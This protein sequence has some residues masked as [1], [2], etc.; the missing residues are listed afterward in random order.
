M[1]GLTKFLF[2]LRSLFSRRKLDAQ[3]TEEIKLHLEMEMEAK[4][5]A[6]MTPEEARYSALREFGNI[7]NIQEKTRDERGWVWL[8]KIWLD[9]R[10]AARVLRKSP[11]FSVT[12][13]LTVSIG[14]GA[15][16]ALFTI[17]NGVLLRPLPF[18]QPDRVVMI[19][20]T[21]SGNVE[22]QVSPAVY[23]DW[24]KQTS[25][26]E[27]L[28]ILSGRSY[29]SRLPGPGEK[30]RAQCVTANYFSVLGV[31]A[32][33]GRT[34]RS[35]EEVEGRNRVVVLSYSFWQSHFGGRDDVLNETL[36]LDDEAYTIVG[37]MPDK[38]LV[39]NPRIFTPRIS[40]TEDREDYGS[41][42]FVCIGRLKPGVSL[43]VAQHELDVVSSRIAQT[44]PETNR[45]RGA[46]LVPLL[47]SLV[48]NVRVQLLT[49]L[50]AVGFLLLIAGTN[51]AGLMLTRA[52]SRAHEIAVR[53]ALGAGQ[54]R[55][56]RQILCESLLIAVMGGVLGTMMAYG[57][58]GPLVRFAGHHVPRTDQIQLDGSVLAASIGL[59]LLTGLCAGLLAAVQS[60]RE[61]MIEPLR[62]VTIGRFSGRRRQRART[63][64]VIF[65]IA[66]TLT[67]LT[68]AG[69]LTR[70]LLSLQRADQ[71][72]SSKNVY[73]AQF[74]LG[75]GLKYNAPEKI[76]TFAR[77]AIARVSAL[78]GVDSA[79]L[80]TGQPMIGFEGLL[81]EVVG[82]PEVPV[83]SMPVT[84]D[85]AVTPDYFKVMG[86][87][88]MQGRGFNAQEVAGAPRA[89]IISEE[90]ARRHFPAVDPIGQ[91]I[92]IMTMANKPDV[93]REIVG[94][95]GDVN[96]SGPQSE[97]IPQVYEPLAQRPQ[98]TLAL[99]VRVKNSALGLPVAVSNA[100]HGIDPNLPFPNVRSYE[101]NMANAWA[102][103]QFSLVIF[104]F[105][106]GAALLLA[107]V[108]IYGTTAYSVEQRT[109]EIGIR[110]ALGARPASV[111]RLVLGFG[112]NIAW[113]GLFFGGFC[114]LVLGRILRSLLFNISPADPVT[115]LITAAFLAIV[116][117]FASWLPARRAAKVDPVIALRAE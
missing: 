72:F 77:D 59:V 91:R 98:S 104:A 60:M 51:V 49:L 38:N 6:G 48:G 21:R 112:I 29:N 89:V 42:N 50:G 35:D 2:Y 30:I 47:S 23:L 85:S 33:L 19:T 113:G 73:I 14:I 65:E 75:G 80:T 107:G 108:G 26:F 90:L 20:E 39:W 61:N 94:V 102:R 92:R 95:V 67:L 106:S 13:I 44:H 93:P 24:V 25:V 12:A 52:S 100:I 1:R 115:L 69:L 74:D 87:P 11:G 103:Q 114:S 27:G 18:D 76:S 88:L 57:S 8:E 70:S 101:V 22:T 99:V 41:H 9:V 36:Q 63:V 81:F 83:A 31:Q 79:A 45:D 34:F 10:H 110:M 117:L 82:A 37:V 78:P 68:G 17:I 109:R 58:L 111:L 55:I 96:P 40:F 105:F 4:V 54:G 32:F 84:F 28:A 62:N 15:C 56:V 43:D 16:T 46:H 66:L 116:T 64:L 97:I 7:A 5:T 71:G 53:I 3:M 86:I